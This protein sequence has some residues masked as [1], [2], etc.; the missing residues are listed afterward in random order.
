MKE[1]KCWLWNNVNYQGIKVISIRFIHLWVGNWNS[2]KLRLCI[3]AQYNH[4]LIKVIETERS[5]LQ[6]L[7]CYKIHQKRR[8]NIKIQLLAGIEALTMLDASVN[9]SRDRP[10]THSVAES[11]NKPFSLSVSI[12]GSMDKNPNGF[13]CKYSPT[14]T[15]PHSAATEVWEEAPVVSASQQAHTSACSTASASTN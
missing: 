4:R 6:P 2:R 7:P 13:S 5:E 8:I 11:C 9:H 15:G 12:F 3:C 1:Q 10:K 14:L